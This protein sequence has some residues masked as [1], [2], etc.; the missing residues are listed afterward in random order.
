MNI[1]FI[2][3]TLSGYLRG[4]VLGL[5]EVLVQVVEFEHLIV[6]RVGIGSAK[7]LP[8]R[9]VHLGAEQPAFVI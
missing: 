3:F 6:E 5:A 8:R 4:D 2:S 7:G 9:S 1:F